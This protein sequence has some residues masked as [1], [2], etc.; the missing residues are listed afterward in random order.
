MPL[1]VR[2][3]VDSITAACLQ[4]IISPGGSLL[5][6]TPSIKVAVLQLGAA[7]LSTPWPIGTSSSILEH[8][9]KCAQQ[10]KMDDTN[11]SMVAASVLRLCDCM[12]TP[13]VPA[14]HVDTQ[15]HDHIIETSN[16]SAISLINDIHKADV[17]HQ[18]RAAESTKLKEE[19]EVKR[20]LE[21]QEK[22]AKKRKASEDTE[23]K[24]RRKSRAFQELE[25]RKAEE[26]AVVETK[27]TSAQ[28]DLQHSTKK[29]P[30][31]KAAKNKVS[32]PVTAE[33]NE[34]AT[35]ENEDEMDFLPG[36]VDDDGP[37]EDDV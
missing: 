10:C 28:N 32:P 21:T 26:M 25:K 15:R 7:C 4:T 6:A 16:V 14:L 36:I 29:T 37:D 5:A 33:E 20:E 31:V 12:A 19:Q 11:S 3:L 24:A 18:E 1:A 23:N 35:M 9:R 27:S 22:E 17:D 30:D 13:R 8:V 2:A 34:E